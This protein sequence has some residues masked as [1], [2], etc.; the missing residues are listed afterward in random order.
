MHYVNF[1]QR[2]IQRQMRRADES[3][4][5]AVCDVTHTFSACPPVINR[6]L[7]STR[8]VTIYCFVQTNIQHVSGFSGLCPQTPP[9]LCPWTPLPQTPLLSPYQIPGYAP[10][11]IQRDVLSQSVRIRCCEDIT[12]INRNCQKFTDLNKAIPKFSGGIN[13]LNPT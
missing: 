12:F 9:G 8:F 6:T 7:N 5:T 11:H 4:P 2:R 13:P 3:P 1:N 10:A